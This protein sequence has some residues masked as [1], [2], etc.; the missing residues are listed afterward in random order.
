MNQKRDDKKLRLAIPSKGALERSTSE[1][2]AAAGLKVSR[3]NDRQYV[4]SISALPDVEVI[5]QRAADIFTKVQE[6]S[7]D[8]GITGYDIYKEESAGYNHVIDIYPELGFGRCELVL[9]VPD[10]WIDIVSMADLA[11][12]TLDFR[13]NKGRNLRIVTKYPNLTRE[14]LKK[15]QIVHFSLVEANGALEAAPKMGYADMIADVS[16][17]GTT[18][19]ENR[20]KPI[21]GDPMLKSQACIIANKRLLQNDRRKQEVT[22]LILDSIE[23]QLEAKKFTSI[24]AN[25]QGDSANELGQRLINNAELAELTG[26]RGP[27][28]AKVYSVLEPNWYAVT[29]VVHQAQWREAVNHLRHTGGTDITVFAPNYIFGSESRHSKQ[30]A[31]ILENKK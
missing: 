15:H 12:L 29:I 13:E 25:I 11:D 14:W 4:G 19:R 20:L 26:M 5:F 16:S 3:P 24:T 28:I 8:L 30:L 18:L 1:L 23:A 31:T 21:T 27:T 6:G 9:A 2:L 17:T 7:V 22:K 10:S